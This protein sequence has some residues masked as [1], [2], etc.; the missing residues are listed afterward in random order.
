MANVLCELTNGVGILTLNRP[1]K[2]NPLSVEMLDEL[3]QA[4]ANFRAY[5]NLR[6]VIL[7][8][9]GDAF[10]AG[11]DISE[12]TNLSEEEARHVSLRGQQLCD[13]IELFPVPVIAAVNGIA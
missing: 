4:L 6:A 13:K 12:L 2:R 11:T 3:S 8:G 9:A 1:D 5:N 10:C 7:T